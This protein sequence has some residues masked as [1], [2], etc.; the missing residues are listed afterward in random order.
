MSDLKQRVINVMLGVHLGDYGGVD[1][2]N[3]SREEILAQTNGRGVTGFPTGIDP[4]Q[5]KIP[6]TRGLPPGSTSDDS[7]LA[8][9]V[10][11]ALILGDG[12]DREWQMLLHLTEL[13]NDVAGWGGTTKRS[14][15]EI[16]KWYREQPRARIKRPPF[17]ST[18]DEKLWNEVEPRDP[19]HPARW[20][21][22]SRGNGV[23]M[24]VAPMGA[25]LA[26]RGGTNAFENGQALKHILELGRLTHADPICTIAAYAVAS[27]VHDRVL[28]ISPEYAYI[29]MQ[30]RVLAAESLLKFLHRGEERFS[31]A[32]RKALSLILDPEAL[33]RFGSGG[34]SDSLTSVPLALAIWRRHHEEYA[35]NA[36]VL[37]AI[38]AGG[39]TDTVA[40]MVGAMMGAG[41]GEEDWWPSDWISQLK[42]RGAL[43]KRLGDDLRGV[44]GRRY[45]G[46][47]SQDREALMRYQLGYT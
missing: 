41:S 4:S 36:A 9:A 18:R 28:D 46:R 5:R 30:A 31:D 14:L 2:E 47:H 7:Q 15:Y 8:N 17:K 16:D 34:A 26:A 37:E 35:P 23:A 13:W 32:L 27:V 29:N 39:D 44:A 10:T 19:R 21:E 38:N 24:K 43:A 3:M 40:S 12:Y 42:D 1:T 45:H 22:K 6:D 33:W 11:N 25:F 20:R